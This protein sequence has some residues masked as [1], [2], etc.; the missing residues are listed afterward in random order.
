[1]AGHAAMLIIDLVSF[2]KRPE[3]IMSVSSLNG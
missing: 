2:S 3:G 1:M